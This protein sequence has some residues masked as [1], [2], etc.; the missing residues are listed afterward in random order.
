MIKIS[1][2]ITT[3]NSEKYIEDFLKSMQGQQELYEVVIV[4]AG[5][6]DKTQEIIKAYAKKNKNIKL[7]IYPGTRPE[8]M[9]YGIKMATG[10]AVTFIGGDDVADKN[11]IKEIRAGLKT[12]DII[13]GKLISLTKNRF[14]TLQNVKVFHKGV[15]ISYPG[16]NTTYKKEILEKLGGFDPWFLSAEDL[17]LNYRAVDAGYKIIYYEKAL[18]YYRPRETI[19]AFI[20]QSFQYGYGR[21]QLALKYK[22]MWGR[23]SIRDTMKT[24]FSVL[25]IVRL[26]L[27]FIGYLFCLITVKKYK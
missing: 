6:T 13:V 7:F 17:E 24:Q 26:T 25:G 23:Y 3:K 10:D 8:S 12:A 14:T 22:K 20:K 21:K 15:N 27:G 5:S 4:D 11:L 18:V 19:Y 16:T 2:V 1:V 9:N